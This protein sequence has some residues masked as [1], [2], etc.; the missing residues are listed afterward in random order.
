[1]GKSLLFLLIGIGI[2]V[3]VAPEKGS[4]TLKSLLGKAQDFKDDAEDYLA[5]ST[6]KIKSKAG[7]VKN[8]VEE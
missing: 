4:D 1:M 3:L 5:D 6:E 2:G 7:K 8:A